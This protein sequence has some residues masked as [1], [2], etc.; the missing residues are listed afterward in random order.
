MISRYKVSLKNLRIWNGVDETIDHGVDAVTIENGYLTFV[1]SSEDLDTT[2]TDSVVKDMSGLSMIPGLIDAH[3]HLCLDPHIKDP[4]E[5][6]KLT[7]GELLQGMTNRARAM[8][9]AGITSA[10]DLGGGQWLELEVRE[11]INRGEMIGPRLICSGQPITSVKGHCHFWGGEAADGAEALKVLARQLE[12]KVDLIKVMATG[13]NITH[14]SRPVDAQFDEE[15]LSLIVNT[16]HKHGLRVAAHCH[17]TSGI[18]NAAA[19]G[20]TTIEHCSWVG[21]EGWGKAFDPEVVARIVK[22]GIWVSPTINSGWKR[23]AGNSNFADLLHGNYDRMREA[24]VKLIA[25]TDAGIPNV[26]HHHLPLAIPVFAHFAGLTATEALR[27]ATSDCAEAIGLGG[28]T[29][30]ISE[31]YSAD[32]VLY[33]GDPTSDLAVLATPV[34]VYKQGESALA[35]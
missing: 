12:H 35:L 27:A 31:G 22:Q 25:S 24:G 9:E 2:A 34:Q 15:T 1:G 16:A 18:R 26:L 4:L 28:V 19:A 33:D 11:S 7:R 6:D 8:L 3:I 13:G 32:F 21:D 23:F 30:Q 29:G 20:V 5:Q 10:R 17:G 14:G